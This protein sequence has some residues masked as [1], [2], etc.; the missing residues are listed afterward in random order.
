MTIHASMSIPSSMR[1]SSKGRFSWLQASDHHRHQGDACFVLLS[2]FPFPP[3]YLRNFFRP[4]SQRNLSPCQNLS[5][6]STLTGDS[7]TSWFY[8]PSQRSYSPDEANSTTIL[9]CLYAEANTLPIIE[10][11]SLSTTSA[12]DAFLQ[13]SLIKS[14]QSSVISKPFFFYCTHI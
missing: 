5:L 4:L 13:I 14:E 9:N 6:C 1:N 2:S 7:R 3:P 10:H 8:S 11:E 12:D